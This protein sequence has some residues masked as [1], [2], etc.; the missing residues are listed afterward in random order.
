MDWGPWCLVRAK[1]L[2]ASQPLRVWPGT[3]LSRVLWGLSKAHHG[4]E[5]VSVGMLR[6]CQGTAGGE[7]GDPAQQFGHNEVENS[8]FC[9]PINVSKA[10][11]CCHMFDFHETY[12][13]CWGVLG[14]FSY[15]ELN[16][17][18]PPMIEPSFVFVLQVWRCWGRLA[19]PV[20]ECSTALWCSC[21]IL[22]L[23]LVT[24]SNSKLTQLKKILSS[25]TIMGP[26]CGE[27]LSF[28][29]CNVVAIPKP[30]ARCFWLQCSMAPAPQDGGSRRPTRFHL[31]IYL[32]V[33][34]FLWDRLTFKCA[35]L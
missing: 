26:L 20:S 34:C 6:G 21:C 10:V 13:V 23:S 1:K 33:F 18:K 9:F 29:C 3:A 30:E 24:Y 19:A 2:P 11:K 32:F 7:T 27:V 22:A 8:Y 31:L 5:A 25:P 12:L 17:K 15:L 28:V 35:A 16:D 14:T 4:E